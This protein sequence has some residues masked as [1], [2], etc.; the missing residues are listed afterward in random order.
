MREGEYWRPA[1]DKQHE[2]MN[3]THLTYLELDNKK[4]NPYFRSPVGENIQNI[5]DVGCGNASWVLTL[6]IDIRLVS[7]SSPRFLFSKAEL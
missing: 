3:L 4:E 1:D 7:S 6:R 5:L 2:S